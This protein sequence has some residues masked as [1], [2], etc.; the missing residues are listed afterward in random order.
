MNPMLRLTTAFLA[1]FIAA[2]ALANDSVAYLRTGGLEFSTT[3]AVVMEKED[4][5]LSPTLVRVNYVFRN[6]TDRPVDIR[7]AFP[8][9]R[10]DMQLALSCQDVAIPSADSENFVDFRTTVNGR[11]VRMDVQT[12]AFAGER[13]ISDL[14]RQL[15]IPFE[16]PNGAILESLKGSSPAALR[17]L[18]EAKAISDEEH[19]D[20]SPQPIWF[21][22]TIFHWQQQFPP[23]VT[24]R[25]SHTYRPSLGA[26]FITTTDR[27]FGSPDRLSP[28]DPDLSPFCVDQG[29]W[30]A[31]VRKGTKSD[32]LVM[33]RFLEYIV[34]TARSWKGPIRDFTL[35]IDKMRPDAIVSLCANGIRKTGPTTF[36]VKRRDFVPDS[37]IAVLFVTAVNSAFEDAPPR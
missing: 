10:L 13:D 16:R 33:G 11:P 24:T 23:G 21:T 17:Q 29:T 31:I 9:P 14:L 25:I 15:N 27:V 18:A 32:P 30:R 26:Q 3:D 35:T 36:E 19:C 8:L 6:V 12:K 37:D 7:V 5:F 4:L 2:P 1:A 34:Q 28:S 20:G 22:E